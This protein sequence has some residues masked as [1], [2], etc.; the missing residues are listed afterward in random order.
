METP[1]RLLIG[2]L[3]LDD[4]G[5]SGREVTKVKP[6]LNIR[7][8]VTGAVDNMDFVVAVAAG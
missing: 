6:V 4:S 5:G 1:V 3:R 2:L 8:A 7:Q